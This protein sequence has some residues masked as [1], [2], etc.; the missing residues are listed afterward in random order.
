MRSWMSSCE[1][2]IPL[3]KYTI[4]VPS[5]HPSSVPFKKPSSFPSSVPSSV[6]SS[7][8]SSV[9]S[10]EPGLLIGASSA[11]E[12]AVGA[13]LILIGL[14]GIKESQEFAE[15]QEAELEKANGDTDD[16]SEKA[17]KRAVIFN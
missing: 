16:A 9:P 10:K 13:S 6:P 4:S 8:P 12:I 1:S 14:L 3:P 7:Q 2:I 5:S 11:M 15:E 17:Q